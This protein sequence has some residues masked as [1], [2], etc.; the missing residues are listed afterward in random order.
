MLCR[1]SWPGECEQW[2][3]LRLP[4]LTI[5]GVAAT[6]SAVL[7]LPETKPSGPRPGVDKEA[8]LKV[9]SKNVYM[10]VLRVPHFVLIT[11][12][13]GCESIS[14]SPADEQCFKLVRHIF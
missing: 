9:R 8:Q 14:R 7:F 6:I 2:R 11:A 1:A 3:R 5:S 12:V 13:F 4:E 10:D